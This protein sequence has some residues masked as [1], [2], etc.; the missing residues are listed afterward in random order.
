[1]G[2][3]RLAAVATAALNRFSSSS[4]G[5]TSSVSSS[6]LP[7]LGNGSSSTWTGYPHGSAVRASASL[8]DFSA[9]YRSASA[10]DGDIMSGTGGDFHQ[11]KPPQYQMQKDLKAYD[12][13]GPKTST[14]WYAS[15]TGSRTTNS[16]CKVVAVL[17]LLCLLVIISYFGLQ[18]MLHWRSEQLQY[19]VVLDCGST[20]TRVQVYAWAYRDSA[21]PIRLPVVIFPAFQQNKRSFSGRKAGRRKE[22]RAYDRMETEPGLDKLLKNESGVRAAVEPL[23]QWAEKQIPSF[24][25]RNTPLFLLAT[26]GLR[27]LANADAEWLLEKSWAIFERSPFMCRRSWL[28]VLSGVE[29][30]YYGWVA[31]NYKLDRLGQVPRQST[32]GALDLGGSS[33][34]V[35]FESEEVDHVE[36]GLNL[37]VGSAEHHLYAYSHAGFGLND[38]FDRSV[39]LIWNRLRNDNA[40]FATRR[41]EIGHPCL[42]AGYKRQYKCS[43]CSSQSSSKVLDRIVRKGT[44]EVVRADIVLVGEPDWE[45]CKVLAD[46][47]VNV[48]SWTQAVDCVEPPCALGRHQPPPHGQFYALSGFFVVYKFFGLHPNAGFEELMNHGKRFCARPWKEAL[49]SVVPQP[50]VEHYCFRAPYVV[51]LL[52]DGL[53]L[54]EDQV[55]VGSGDMTWT[56]GAA[57]LE[58]GAFVPSKIRGSAPRRSSPRHFFRGPLPLDT[59]MV[60]V[61]LL[62]MMLLVLFAV[63]CFHNCHA[64]SWRKS[65][66]PLFTQPSLGSSGWFSSILPSSIR[67][68]YNKLDNA[69]QNGDG[70]Y[71]TPHSPAPLGMLQDHHHLRQSPLSGVG[72]SSHD[73]SGLRLPD[74]TGGLPGPFA[75]IKM[76][77]KGNSQLSSRRTLSKDD[78]SFYLR[79]GHMSKG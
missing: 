70:R 25:H 57:L 58:A 12:S 43:R 65:H 56:L 28:K 64:L 21:G 52:Q 78:L 40:D 53:H 30:A 59:G 47:V 41:V 74:V 48:S 44:K 75:S 7:P 46:A 49:D 19:A 60:T 51:A 50:L 6:N 29:E 71:K 77:H 8:Q 61:S 17:N 67:L 76:P 24:A 14:S 66:L 10:E 32:F 15:V 1:M 26:A 62:V 54:R 34:Q 35:T 63:T 20:G 3:Q 18:W 33:L 11:T 2:F 31:L 69:N 73:S 38:A 5:I 37:S 79:D 68:G 23:L 72:N 55:V 13:K 22:T 36:Y 45:A 27:R 9:L 16:W 42:Q 4:S 39:E